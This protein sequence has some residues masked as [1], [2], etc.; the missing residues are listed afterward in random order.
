L[1]LPSLCLLAKHNIGFS[2]NKNPAGVAVV[3][4]K[5]PKEFDTSGVIKKLGNA[6][7]EADEHTLELA[8]DSFQ[9]LTLQGKA[10][11]RFLREAAL[12]IRKKGGHIGAASSGRH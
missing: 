6:V 1:Q 9:T 7:R 12:A 2:Y 3:E 4:I 8:Y 11:E 10:A 5:L